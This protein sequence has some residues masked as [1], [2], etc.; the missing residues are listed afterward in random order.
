LFLLGDANPKEERKD[1]YGVLGDTPM[2]PAK[3]LCPFAHPIC[4]WGSI[5][6]CTEEDMPR[7][8]PQKGVCDGRCFF[9]F[10]ESTIAEMRFLWGN[11]ATRANLVSFAVVHPCRGK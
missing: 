10:A 8:R 6:L 4:V 1:I 11:S 9:D 5:R 3:G 2:P 7:R